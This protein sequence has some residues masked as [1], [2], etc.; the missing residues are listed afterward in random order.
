M[1]VIRGGVIKAAADEDDDRTGSRKSSGNNRGEGLGNNT[2][3]VVVHEGT[4]RLI[5]GPGNTRRGPKE[6]A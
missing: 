5:N 3:G 2:T 6:F 4:V 1:A